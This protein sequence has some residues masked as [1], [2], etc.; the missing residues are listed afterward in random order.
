MRIF[1]RLPSGTDTEGATSRG[2]FLPYVRER[3]Y[4]RPMKEDEGWQAPESLRRRSKAD[5]YPVFQLYST[6]VPPEVRRIE[7]MTFGEWSASQESLGRMTQ[8]V[9]ED[10]GRVDGWLRV[11]GDGD[12]GRFDLQASPAALD[13]LIEAALAKVSN[14]ERAVTIVPEYQVE[15]AGR[16]ERLGFEPGEEFTVLSRR[17]VRPIKAAKKVPAVVQTTFG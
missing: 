3:V 7:G 13:T 8:Y 14:R 6:V 12:I 11:A 5:P 10:G 15:L 4:S 9:L 2:G 16:L 17:T 1:V